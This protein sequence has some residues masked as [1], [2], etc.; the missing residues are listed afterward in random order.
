MHCHSFTTFDILITAG[1][2]SQLAGV[3]AGFAF[4]ALMFLAATRISS[5]DRGHAFADAIRILVAAFISLVLTSLGYAI[6]AGEPSTAY[7]RIASEEPILGVGFAV[8]GALVI[9]AIVLTLDAANRLVKRPS[10]VRPEVGASTR[11][12]LAMAGVPLLMFYIVQATQQDYVTARYGPCH[13][14]VALD[15]LG[16]YLLYAQVAASW[17]GYTLLYLFG[18]RATSAAAVSRCAIWA[19]RTLL[20]ITFG[21]AIAFAL[22][23]ARL[24][25]FHTLPPIFPATCLVV[26]FLAMLGMTWLLA[27]TGPPYRGRNAANSALDPQSREHWQVGGREPRLVRRIRQDFPDPRSCTEVLRLI[28]TLE[29]AAAGALGTERVQAAVVLIAAGNFNKFLDAL[30]TA[31]RDWRDV[32]KTAGL[33]YSDWMVRM[34]E[35]LGTDDQ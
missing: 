16:T 6:F 26:M 12:L 30:A 21:S 14:T 10:A 3:L 33:H 13:G 7:K 4:T 2:Y 18:R 31:G 15:R 20:S 27:Y 1:F 23:D 22:V 5:P 8:S 25:R 9:Y 34:E 19:S 32:L 24:P 11:R 17:A 29:D 35:E 28:G